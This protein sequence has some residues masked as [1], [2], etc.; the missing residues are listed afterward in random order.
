MRDLRQG[1]SFQ[2]LSLSSL[3]GFWQVIQACELQLSSLEKAALGCGPPRTLGVEAV[4]AGQSWA[5][6]TRFLQARPRGSD[7]ERLS[8]AHRATS[9]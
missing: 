3:R 8:R 9:L 7:A 4:G 6:E 1:V 5:L 2:T